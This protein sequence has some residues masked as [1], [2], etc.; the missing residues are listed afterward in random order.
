MLFKSKGIPDATVLKIVSKILKDSTPTKAFRV[1]TSDGKKTLSYEEI[2]KFIDALAVRLEDGR[3]GVIR[4][5]DTCGNFSPSGQKGRRGCCSP[6]EHTLFREPTEYCSKWVPMTKEQ[7]H[8]K[9]VLDGHFKSLQTK[10][11]GD[12]SEDSSESN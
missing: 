3:Y 10:R 12:G 4:R 5:C 6:K 9:E 2:I 1:N 11:A 7:K 8:I